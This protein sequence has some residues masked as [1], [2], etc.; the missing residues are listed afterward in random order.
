LTKTPF[1]QIVVHAVRWRE[2]K[3]AHVSYM[4]TSGMMTRKERR[5]TAKQLYVQH[6]IKQILLQTVLHLHLFQRLH[7]LL[8]LVRW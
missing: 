3:K 2:E 5:K 1:D 7:E 4:G 8:L 6:N